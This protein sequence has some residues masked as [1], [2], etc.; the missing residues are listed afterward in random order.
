MTKD[1]LI[2]DYYGYNEYFEIKNKNVVFDA[3]YLDVNTNDEIMT[4]DLIIKEDYSNKNLF[5]KKTR[6]YQF[7]NPKIIS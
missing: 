4:L 3:L 6:I 1:S 5:K 7:S 2:R